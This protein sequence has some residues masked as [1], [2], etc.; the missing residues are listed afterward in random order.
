VVCA[1]SQVSKQ[2]SAANR[3]IPVDASVPSSAQLPPAEKKPT[4]GPG[5][6]DAKPALWVKP[7]ANSRVVDNSAIKCV[8][9]LSLA[10]PA[11]NHYH[12][13]LIL[14]LIL[15]LLHDLYRNL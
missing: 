15:I 4:P 12:Y 1:E 8:E 5:A 14:I 6:F 3:A 2:L 10:S 7:S 11:H 9:C 13:I